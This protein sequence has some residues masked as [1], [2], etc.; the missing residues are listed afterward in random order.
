VLYIF[1][2][3]ALYIAGDRRI[4]S[5]K[6]AFSPSLDFFLSLF[7]L[8]F[9]CLPSKLEFSFAVTSICS[10]LFSYFISNEGRGSRGARGFL[11]ECG[12][13]TIFCSNAAFDRIFVRMRLLLEFLFECCFCSNAASPTWNKKKK[14]YR[15]VNS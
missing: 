10:R 7:H 2:T 15:S 5:R 12:F 9:S 4:G 14:F 13:C 8:N 1:T 6:S 11:F 3:P